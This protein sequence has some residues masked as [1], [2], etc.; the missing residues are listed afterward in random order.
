MVDKFFLNTEINVT[1]LMQKDIQ[2]TIAQN[3]GIKVPDSMIGGIYEEIKWLKYPYISASMK[4]VLG[5][6]KADIKISKNVD[7]LKN[8]IRYR[9]KMCIDKRIFIKRNGS[10]V[11]W[12]FFK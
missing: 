9:C 7:E 11:D 1:D 10:L 5:A 8:I 6:E 2:T 12:I 3:E 4:R